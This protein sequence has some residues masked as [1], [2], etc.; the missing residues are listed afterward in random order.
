MVNDLPQRASYD[1]KIGDKI[2]FFMGEREI[3]VRVTSLAESPRKQE[4]ALMY[5]NIDAPGRQ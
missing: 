2:S 3:S 4:A 1:V 5:K